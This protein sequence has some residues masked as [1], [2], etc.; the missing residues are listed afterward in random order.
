MRAASM[1]KSAWYGIGGRQGDLDAG[2][3]LGDASGDLD[4]AEAD[5][6]ELCIAPEGGTGISKR[7]GTSKMSLGSRPPERL[8]L[9]TGFQYLTDLV[10]PGVVAGQQDGALVK[11][12]NRDFSAANPRRLG[13][14]CANLRDSSALAR[15]LKACHNYFRDTMSRGTDKCR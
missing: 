9:P 14:R 2:D 11:F 5:R 13:Q 4:Q 12:G 3:H 8:V 15:R 1:A 10:D 6:V 7:A